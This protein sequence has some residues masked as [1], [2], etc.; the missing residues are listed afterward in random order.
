[1]SNT[2]HFNVVVVGAGPAGMTAAIYAARS[3]MKTVILEAGS[4][5]GQ[6]AESPEIENYLGFESVNGMD[7]ASTFRKHTERYVEIKEGEEIEQIIPERE[8]IRLKTGWS[9]YTADAAIIA[10][11]AHHR[12]LGCNGEEE[13]SGRGISYC[14]TCDGFFFKG[15]KVVMIGGGN[16]AVGDALYLKNV[17]VDVTIIHRRDVF[18]A[19]AAHV[20]RLEESGIPKIMNSEVREIYGEKVV[21]G[22]KVLNKATGDVSDVPVDGVFIAVGVVPNTDFLKESGIKLDDIGYIVTDREQRTSLPRIYA[23]GDVTGG[24][25]QIIVGCGEGAVAATTAYEDISNPYWK[26]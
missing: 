10:T 9:E 14:A 26:K 7:L 18:R 21:K 13:F 1:M 4:V 16:T 11:G 5:G 8:I 17:G 2:E 24:L 19:E 20:K 3:G 23:A 15:K 6:V 12:K 25:Q 22:V